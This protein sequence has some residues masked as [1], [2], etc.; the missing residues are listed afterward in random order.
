MNFTFFLLFAAALLLFFT[1]LP[2]LTASLQALAGGRLKAFLHRAAGTPLRSF[3]AGLALTAA[4]H[5]SSA[6]TVLCV[7]LADS[8]ILGRKQ[9]AAIIMGS[10]IGTTVT[11]HLLWLS[12]YAGTHAATIWLAPDHLGPLLMVVG[13]GLSLPF[14]RRHIR[15]IGGVC[16][17]LGMILA[18]LAGME[19]GLSPLGA[20]PQVQRLFAQLSH[21][22]AGVFAGTAVTALLQSSSTSVTLLQ[23]FAATG[24]VSFSAAAAI[25]CGQNIGT[26]STACLAAMGGGDTGRFVARFHLYL[27]VLG[28]ATFLAIL[29]LLQLFL[30][31]WIPTTPPDAKGIALLHTVFNVFSTVLFLPVLRQ[32]IAL[33]SRPI[34]P[35]LERRKRKHPS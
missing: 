6:V 22:L 19:T 24:T 3:C 8:G 5:S 13:I 29:T 34:F 2:L 27:N 16:L 12:N 11:A 9:L 25:I 20:L 14:L 35:A 26:C 15:S 10:N 4:V 21:P 1:G 31:Q 7:G 18:G 28:A 33:A 17:G 23:A 30:P 32:L